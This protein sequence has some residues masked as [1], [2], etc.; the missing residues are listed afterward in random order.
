MKQIYLS[1]LLAVFLSIVG[2]KASAYDIVVMN[3]DGAY[4]CY[5][6]IN[7]KT[8]LA[9]AQGPVT[10]SSSTFY[11]GNI[12]IPESVTYNDNTYRV[13][14]IANYAFSTNSWSFFDSG[15]SGSGLTSVTIPNSVTEIGFQAFFGCSNLTSVHISDLAAWCKIEFGGDYSNPL[16]Y[17]HHLYLNGEEIKDLVIPNSVTSVFKELVHSN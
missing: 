14:S 6:F 11:S 9:V 3:E 7:N 1:S 13:T 2:T 8:E 4:I 10:R 17:A 12:V 15:G 5:N 16:Y